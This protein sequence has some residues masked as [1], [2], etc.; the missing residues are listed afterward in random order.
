[1]AGWLRSFAAPFL[2]GLEDGDVMLAQA[3][4]ALGSLRDAQGQWHA[5]CVRLRFAA[6]KPA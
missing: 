4:A 5:D 1:M 6:R 2:A 3:E